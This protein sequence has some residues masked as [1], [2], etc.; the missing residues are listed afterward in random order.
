MQRETVKCYL[1]PR[2]DKQ[3]FLT[4]LCTCVRQK[5]DNFPLPSSFVPKPIVPAF[6]Q[7]NL[8]VCK[9]ATEHLTSIQ[10]I[11]LWF[12]QTKCGRDVR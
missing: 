1:K 3:V 8:F 12:W 11:C 10:E 5:M 6:G 7:G 2:T 4:N 9:A